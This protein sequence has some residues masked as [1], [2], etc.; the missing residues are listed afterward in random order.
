MMI[1]VLSELCRSLCFVTNISTIPRP[2]NSITHAISHYLEWPFDQR[3]RLTG[4]RLTYGLLTRLFNK[5]EASDRGGGQLTGGIWPD[6]F[7]SILTRDTILS[8]CLIGL[9]PL[10]CQ[11]SCTY[12][13][14]FSAPVLQFSKPNR[15][16]RIQTVK[17]IWGEKILLLKLQLQKKA[18][19][20]LFYGHG[21]LM[22]R[23][24]VYSFAKIYFKIELERKFIA[25]PSYKQTTRK[26]KIL[27][28]SYFRGLKRN[29]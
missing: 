26:R 5:W 2:I 16:H 17:Y 12:H 18:V 3:G 22:N 8:V 1:T 14:L 7:V 27:P 9:T 20:L 15:R 25:T 23:D 24:A 21:E 19:G 4:G 13:H 11:N 29:S 10:F 28:S 6:T